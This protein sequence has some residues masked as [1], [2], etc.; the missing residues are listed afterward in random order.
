MKNGTRTLVLESLGQIDPLRAKNA[1]F[2]S[3]FARSASA[4]TPG[5]KVQLSLIGSLLRT[6]QL[7]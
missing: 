5:E 4:V 1:Y 2:Q 3:M 6:F 7:A